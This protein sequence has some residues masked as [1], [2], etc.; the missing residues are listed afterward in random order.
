M[1]NKIYYTVNGK[2]ITE[3]DVNDFI[4]RLGQDGI[5]FNS[6]EGKKQVAEELL[7]QEM[8]LLDAKEK[9]LDQEKEYI[10]QI[11]LAKDQLLKQI[12]MQKLLNDVEISDE[13]VKK[14]YDDNSDQFK[15]VYKFKAFHIL[16]DEEEKAKELKERIDNGED[17]EELA[18]SDSKCPSSQK[19]GDLGEFQ[20]GQMVPEFENAL[21]EMEIGDI[22]EPVKTQFGYH[23][24]RLDNKEIAR[25]NN[26][27]TFKHEI[28][29]ALLNQKQQE[30]YLKRVEELKE[31]YNIEEK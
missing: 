24:I 3:K 31:K 8:L 11:E 14:F 16:V 22:S 27:E 12:A 26:F 2:D 6:E 21:I 17:F 29:N 4:L 15:D 5:R 10:E 23:L 30:V 9:K 18:K 1:E 25:E 20:S 13:E 19:G 28:R 7:N